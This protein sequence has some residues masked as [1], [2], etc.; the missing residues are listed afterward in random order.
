MELKTRISEHFKQS[1]QLKL[2]LASLLA[3]PISEAAEVIV[4]A[5]LNEKKVLS[6]G[7]G[8]SAATSLQR[9]VQD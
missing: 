2:E 6:C 3:A 5:L 1:G 4:Q 9:P 8:G 7:N